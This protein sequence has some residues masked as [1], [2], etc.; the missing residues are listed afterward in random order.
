MVEG[1]A[2]AASRSNVAFREKVRTL[3]EG[4][5]LPRGNATREVSSSVSPI[6]CSHWMAI[7]YD[8]MS[9]IEKSLRRNAGDNWAQENVAPRATA[10]SAL[11]VLDVGLPKNCLMRCLMAGTIIVPPTRLTEWVS[12]RLLFL[13]IISSP[14]ITMTLL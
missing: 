11:S 6:E 12:A 10:S 1:S 14:K 5:W 13:S 4:V 9:M 8:A 3:V 2:Y 7:G